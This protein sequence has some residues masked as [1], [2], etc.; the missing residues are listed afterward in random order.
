MKKLY[1]S[2]TNKR[3]AGVCGGIGEMLDIDPTIVRVA[4]VLLA[5]TTGLLPF[6][7]GYVI[8][9]LVFPVGKQETVRGSA[10]AAGKP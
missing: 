9:W 5:L 10:A 3:I 8:A 7:V 4:T 2:E 6:L 1:R